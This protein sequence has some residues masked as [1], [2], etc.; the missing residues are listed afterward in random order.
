MLMWRFDDGVARV[1]SALPEASG[2]IPATTSAPAANRARLLPTIGAILLD[3]RSR[4]RARRGSRCAGSDRTFLTG[5]EP[6][7]EPK[8]VLTANRRAGETCADPGF[9]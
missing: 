6:S 9:D 7:T 2:T 8:F 3:S 5:G 1:A 4:R